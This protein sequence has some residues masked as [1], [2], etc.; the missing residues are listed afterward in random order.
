M[1]HRPL[2]KSSL[3]RQSSVEP[4]PSCVFSMFNNGLSRSR[5]SV[6][7]TATDV[8]LNLGAVPPT[9]SGDS[10]TLTSANQITGTLIVYHSGT[11]EKVSVLT[12]T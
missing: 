7:Y 9:P 4:Y 10:P 12:L 5:F 6:Q 8:H 11:N 2:I 3:L 1:K